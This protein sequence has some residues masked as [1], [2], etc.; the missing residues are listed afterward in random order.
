MEPTFESQGSTIYGHVAL[1]ER[2]R[3]RGTPAIVLCHGFPDTA[4]GAEGAARSYPGLADRLANELGWIAMSFAYSGCGQ[5]EGNFSTSAWLADVHAAIEHLRS[6]HDTAG[7]WL[8]GF[9]TGGSLAICA[10][11]ADEEIRGVAAFSAPADFS[12]WAADP[13]HLSTHAKQIGA[14]SDD[15]FPTDLEAWAKEFEE[16][17]ATDAAPLVHPRSL[18][19]VHGADDGL[20]PVFDGRI[21]ADAHGEAELRVISGAGHR[22]RYDPRAIAILL[23]WLTRQV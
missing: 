17:S 10:A 6:A 8:A 11:A 5:S 13:T 4:V 21:L 16:V 18:L 3:S 14:I 20:V 1:P 12:D 2:L 7:I 9:G 23:G 15:E 19:V 22:L